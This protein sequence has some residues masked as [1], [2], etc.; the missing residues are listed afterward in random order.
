MVNHLPIGF[1]HAKSSDQLELKN[2]DTEAFFGVGEAKP[3]EALVSEV[4]S[5]ASRLMPLGV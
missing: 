2:L 5:G 1:R 4:Q 3:L